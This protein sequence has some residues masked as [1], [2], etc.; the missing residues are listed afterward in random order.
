MWFGSRKAGRAGQGRG[1]GAVHL[2]SVEHA[3]AAR[4]HPVPAVVRAVVHSEYHG[5]GLLARPDLRPTLGSLQV[6]RPHRAW[7]GLGL[8]ASHSTWTDLC[9]I[10]GQDIFPFYRKGYP[11]ARRRTYGQRQ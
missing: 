9:R 4:E 10:N 3:A 5:A 2:V 8:A 6:C 1:L 7:V 11:H